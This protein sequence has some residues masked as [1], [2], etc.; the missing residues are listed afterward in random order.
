MEDGS[1]TAAKDNNN[2]QRRGH[3]GRVAS[4][5]MAAR[6]SGCRR[7]MA[8]VD[9]IWRRG[10]VR[11]AGAR[12]RRGAEKGAVTVK[13]V[14]SQLGVGLGPKNGRRQEEQTPS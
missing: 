11:I 13:G 5:P 7:P 9:G 4:R 3:F 8:V 2:T 12:E 14:E 1:Q 6:R 10:G